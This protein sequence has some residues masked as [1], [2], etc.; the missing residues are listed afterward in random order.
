MQDIMALLVMREFFILYNILT[1]LQLQVHLLIK[2]KADLM[3]MEF[4]ILTEQVKMQM[5][6]MA[7]EVFQQLQLWRLQDEY[8]R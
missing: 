5:Q 8:S 3:Q 4:Y 1:V 2:F 7:Q 6:I